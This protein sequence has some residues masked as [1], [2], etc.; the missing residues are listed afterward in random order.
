MEVGLG[1]L[2]NRRVGGVTA[3]VLAPCGEAVSGA[4]HVGDER[5]GGPGQ[6]RVVGDEEVVAVAVAADALIAVFIGRDLDVVD[7]D[8]AGLFDG[9]KLG[10]NEQAELILRGSVDQG[11]AD[12]AVVGL[13]VVAFDP[14]LDPCQSVCAVS[15]ETEVGSVR[16][17]LGD[18]GLEVSLFVIGQSFEG[19]LH[20]CC[21]VVTGQHVQEVLADDLRV[22][23]HVKAM[24]A[25]CDEV[26][27]VVIG[28]VAS[29]VV[30]EDLVEGLKGKEARVGV[31]GRAVGVCPVLRDEGVENT[32]LDHLALDLVAVL[33]EGHGER[34]G[35]LQRVSGQ[36]IEDL[37]VLGL[38]PFELHVVAGVDGLKVLDEEGQRALA[39]AGVADAIEHF[40][41]GLFN[42]LL[43]KLLKGHAFG[44]LDDLLGLGEVF[45]LNRSGSF[46]LG[47][48]LRRGIFRGGSLFGLC[49]LRGG[50]GG[51]GCAGGHRQNHG[52][53]KQKC[54]NLF[55]DMFPPMKFLPGT[56][57]ALFGCFHF[58]G[59]LHKRTGDKPAL[60]CV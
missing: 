5:A 49:R 33:D 26:P 58:T 39:A 46:G 37:V 9:A 47:G 12:G 30:H 59:H 15:A 52:H 1:F 2:G 17:H 14:Q 24:L 20:P 38:L 53:C 21:V 36:L 57:L 25:L 10:V 35:V 19:L 13:R 11:V 22:D 40:A 60:F 27:A 41:V 34:A 8:G 45:L 18:G 50:L 51:R 23:V 29:A 55:H 42:G 6:R 54:K 4:G 56:V 16:F 7:G 3:H 43:G 48:S 32:G 44:F 31:C 28:L